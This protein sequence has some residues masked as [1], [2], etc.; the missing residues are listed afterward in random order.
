MKG[1]W[2][3]NWKRDLSVAELKPRW[4]APPSKFV[5]IGGMQVHVRDEGPRD[6]PT[7]VVLLHGLAG[8]LHHWHGWAEVLKARRRVIRLD[9]PAFGLTGPAPDGNYAV[10]AYVRFMRTALDVLGVERCVMAGNSFGGLVAFQTTLAQPERVERLILVCAA[11][12]ELRPDSLPLGLRLALAPG[13]N[14]LLAHVRSRALI[15]SSARALF[16]DGTRLT[17][18][19]VDLQYEIG[20]REGNRRALPEFLRQQHLEGMHASRIPELKLPTLILW[21]ARDR[22]TPLDHARRF[23]REIAGSRLAVFDDLGHIPQVED[24][25]RTVAEVQRF[26]G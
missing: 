26:L 5:P 3:R 20:L 19:F 10:D 4:A 17:R 11:G 9:L 6:D 13:I 12:Y 7:P 22:L 15:E 21:G 1:R 24:P 16:G 14:R 8:N 23:H 25:L 2:P 18:E